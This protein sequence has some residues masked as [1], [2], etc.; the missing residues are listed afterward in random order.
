MFNKISGG[1]WLGIELAN[2]VAI[3]FY[4]IIGPNKFEPNVILMLWAIYAHLKVVD[5]NR[6]EKKND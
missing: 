1:I 5:C 3:M 6:K 2:L 4:N